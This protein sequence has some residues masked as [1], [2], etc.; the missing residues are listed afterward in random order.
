MASI[1]PDDNIVSN[2]PGITN[3]DPSAIIDGSRVTDAL[4]KLND[5]LKS[6]DDVVKAVELA[7]APDYTPE[8][9]L[10]TRNTARL[11]VAGDF[12]STPYSNSVVVFDSLEFGPNDANTIYQNDYTIEVTVNPGE[13][14]SIPFTATP[15]NVDAVQQL[16]LFITENNPEFGVWW[17][18]T[19]PGGPTLKLNSYTDR[20]GLGGRVSLESKTYFVE[21]SSAMDANVEIYGTYGE[22]VPTQPYWL[23]FA[24]T[25]GVGI[26]GENDTILP[27]IEVC[28]GTRSSVIYLQGDTIQYEVS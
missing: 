25:T 19:Q 5:S 1:R 6:L 13:I 18:S 12:T 28:P 8:F 2:K 10:A 23:N 14:F 17:L 27:E 9:H 24:Y 20:R 21:S 4:L 11:P 15:S 3:P 22:I 7:G 16:E 26:F